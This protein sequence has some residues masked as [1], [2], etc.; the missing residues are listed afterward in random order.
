MTFGDK[1]LGNWE[2]T[3]YIYGKGQLRDSVPVQLT[4]Q[5]TASPDTWTWK[6]SYLSKT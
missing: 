2:G 3:M 4:V 6:T 1:C 5:K